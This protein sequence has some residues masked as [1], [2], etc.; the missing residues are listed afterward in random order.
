MQLLAVKFIFCGKSYTIFGW[1]LWNYTY[2]MWPSMVTTRVEMWTRLIGQ[3]CK[4]RV[5]YAETL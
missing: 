3:F 2:D 5:E 1:L 4:K